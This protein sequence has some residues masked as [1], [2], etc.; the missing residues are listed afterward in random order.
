M[1]YK[2]YYECVI[3]GQSTFK[4]DTIYCD[5]I[6]DGYMQLFNLYAGIESIKVYKAMI[7]PEKVVDYFPDYDIN[8]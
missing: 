2:F 6:A 5:N 3:N 8:T 1:R 7:L 4:T